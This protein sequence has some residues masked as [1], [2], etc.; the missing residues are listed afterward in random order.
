MKSIR[1]FFAASLIGAVAVA[2]VNVAGAQDV[3]GAGATF[4]ALLYAKWAADYNK[5]VAAY[6]AERVK[7]YRTEAKS[8]YQKLVESYPGSEWAR[9][10]ADRLVTMGSG[11]IKEELDG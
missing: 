2:F 4:P 11:G 3:T 8:Y 9:R 10:A 5:A 6:A 1:K 7:V